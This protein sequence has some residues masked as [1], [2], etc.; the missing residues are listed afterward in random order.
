MALIFLV[1][2]L[3]LNVLAWLKWSWRYSLILLHLL[4]GS[5]EA[6]VNVW[7]ADNGKAGAFG[8]VSRR[9]AEPPCSVIDVSSKPQDEVPCCLPWWWQIPSV[10]FLLPLFISA[11]FYTV[12]KGFRNSCLLNSSC[13]EITEVLSFLKYAVVWVMAWRDVP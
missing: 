11:T 1:A 2:V 5:W 3:S 13:L 7:L 9:L 10:R 4:M 12:T 8:C 6:S